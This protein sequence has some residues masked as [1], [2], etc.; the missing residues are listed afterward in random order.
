MLY[1]TIQALAL[2]AAL[3]ISG[4]TAFSLPSVFSQSLEFSVP[5]CS[6]PSQD[7]SSL[8]GYYSTTVNGGMSYSMQVCGQLPGAWCDVLSSFCAYT[9][10][11]LTGISYG[12]FSNGTGYKWSMLPGQSSYAAGA[13]MTMTN[14]DPSPSC[15]PRIVNVAFKCVLD[16]TGSVLLVG[17]VADCQW[18][19][20]VLSTA[21]CLIVGPPNA[22]AI[23]YE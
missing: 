14:G 8:A 20:T 16:Q 5:N 4:T 13:M 11:P 19:F 6:I 23:A 22:T 2:I 9:D 17:E 18:N 7:F 1:R 10:G 15:S 21:A 12:S 3:A